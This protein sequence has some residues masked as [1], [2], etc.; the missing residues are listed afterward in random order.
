MLKVNRKS[1]YALMTV[2]HL[3]K[4]PMGTV[5][6]SQQLAEELGVPEDLLAKV[7]Q[8]LK[9]AQILQAS[10]GAGGGYRLLR[11]LSD[12]RFVDVIAPFEDHMAMV[13]CCE[14]PI[15][16]EGSAVCERLDSCG[17]RQPITALNELLH[18]Q[19]AEL[20]MD[21]FLGWRSRPEGPAVAARTAQVELAG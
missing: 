18:S 19:M 2:Q 17:V 13:S 16:S 15:R 8:G 6:A 14:S 10:K 21:R 11:A 5:M 1:E 3:A 12:L 4:M 7:L 20:T 9:R